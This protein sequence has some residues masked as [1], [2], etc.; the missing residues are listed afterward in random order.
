MSVAYLQT[1][2]C[3]TSGHDRQGGARAVFGRGD[4]QLDTWALNSQPARKRQ[5]WAEKGKLG[6]ALVGEAG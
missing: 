5:I 2:L 6:P 4:V 1:E 3:A